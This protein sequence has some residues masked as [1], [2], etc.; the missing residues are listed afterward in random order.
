[1]KNLLE[2]ILINL[3]DHPDDI[4][5]EEEEQN[6][7]WLYTIFVN[8][9]DVGRVIGRGGSVISAIRQIA[10]IRAMKEQ[11]RVRIVLGEE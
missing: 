8:P 11:L 7:E 3:V 6:G 2:F 4:R 5:I 1:M 9:D 10:T